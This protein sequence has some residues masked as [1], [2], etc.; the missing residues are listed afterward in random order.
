[1]ASFVVYKR[2]NKSEYKKAAKEA[3]NGIKKWFDENP[4]RRVCHTEL[5]QGIQCTVTRK[6]LVEVITGHLEEALKDPEKV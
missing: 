2:M 1:M 4:K 5:W 6:N 3:L